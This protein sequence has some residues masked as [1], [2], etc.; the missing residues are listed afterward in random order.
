MPVT[1]EKIRAQKIYSCLEKKYN[2]PKTPLD[3]RYPYQL[4]IAVI[5]SAQCTDRQVNIVTKEL[6][7]KYPTLEMFVAAKLADLEKIIYSTGFYKVKANKVRGFARKLFNEYNSKLPADLKKLEEFPGIGR[8]TA[9]VI[10]QE[11]H[12]Q[13]EGVVVDTHVTRISGLLKLTSS[14]NPKIIEQDLLALIPPQKRR[15][16]SL[17]L[18][19]LGRENCTARKRLCSTCV[20]K[21]IC[22]SSEAIASQI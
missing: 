4:A 12:Q 18:I 22:P 20:L 13:N 10:Q 3:Y 7:Q 19:F 8:K 11:I 16:W 17:Y 15:N 14:R 5:L 9:N 1:L 21:N 2:Q 6:F